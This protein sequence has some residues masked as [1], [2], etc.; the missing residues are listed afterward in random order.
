MKSHFKLSLINIQ[1]CGVFIVISDTVSSC[2]HCPSL[3]IVSSDSWSQ[4]RDPALPASRQPVNRN[5][6]SSQIFTVTLRHRSLSFCPKVT[7]QTERHEIIMWSAVISL[8]F[9]FRT[10]AVISKLFWWYNFNH[11]ALYITQTSYYN[12]FLV[13]PLQLGTYVLEIIRKKPS[14]YFFKSK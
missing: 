6:R 4:C 13:N 14:N 8:K 5:K 12:G 2:S 10:L 11:N 3:Q 9:Q 1:Q 7:Y